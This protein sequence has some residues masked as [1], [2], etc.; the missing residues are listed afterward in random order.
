VICGST[1]NT[2]AAAAAYAAKADMECV[3]LVP[4]G[5]IA[6]GKLA[7]AMVYGAKVLQIRG[8]FDQALNLARELTQHLP[9]HDR[10]LDQ[11]RPHRGPKDRRLRDRRRAG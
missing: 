5:K 6:L 9:D 2:S 4:E 7:Q 8:N 11:P 3:V 10:Q 1:G